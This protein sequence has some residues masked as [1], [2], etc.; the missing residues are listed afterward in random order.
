MR[1]NCNAVN[2]LC[3][4]HG[5]PAATPAAP[6]EIPARWV[7]DGSTLHGLPCNDVE[8]DN[9]EGDNVEDNGVEGELREVDAMQRNMIDKGARARVRVRGLRLRLLER[10]LL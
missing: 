4:P 8:G 7:I 1:L 3:C 6:A 9:V 2:V 5:T 10:W